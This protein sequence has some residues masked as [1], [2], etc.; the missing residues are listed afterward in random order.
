MTAHDVR[1]NMMLKAAL[2]CCLISLTLLPLISSAQTNST[3]STD[4]DE[5]L[6]AQSAGLHQWGALTLFH[7][8]PSDRVRAIAEDAEGALWFATD[9]G[10]AR[11]DGRRT[12]TIAA[13]GL[14]TG[15][16]L[17]L[18]FESHSATL[19]VGTEAG[20]TRF[21]GKR[22]QAITETAGHSITAIIIPESERAILASEQ[23]V[24]FDCHVEANGYGGNGTRVDSAVRVRILP[25]Q[26][27]QSADAD[28]LDSCA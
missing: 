22:F 5:T 11:Y 17:A 19:W 14:P 7:G 20:A 21:N 28:V 25:S 13:E 16:V 6:A 3:D 24:I 4:G 27:L 26:P 23:G 15:R 8:L 9:A 12:Q 18:K 2:A 1:S 10:L